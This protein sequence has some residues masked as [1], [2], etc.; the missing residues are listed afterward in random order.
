MIR[1]SLKSYRCSHQ[2][3]APQLPLP[4]YIIL[5]YFSL[6]VGLLLLDHLDAGERLQDLSLT[7]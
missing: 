7:F 3:L 1:C 4:N 6:K 5:R 2:H